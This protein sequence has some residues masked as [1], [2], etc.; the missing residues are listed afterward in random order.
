MF[1][2]HFS[3]SIPLKF[4]LFVASLVVV[5]MAVN[6]YFVVSYNN[7]VIRKSMESRAQSIATSLSFTGA[8]VVIDNLYLIQGSLAGFFAL[9]AEF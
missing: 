8:Q 4:S 6:T 7:K 3:L 2:K 5:T 1:K 9:P